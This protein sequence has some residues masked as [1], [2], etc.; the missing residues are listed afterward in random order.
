M[1]HRIHMCVYFCLPEVDFRGRSNWSQTLIFP[2]TLD[3][4]RIFLNLCTNFIIKCNCVLANETICILWQALP[5]TPQ[6]GD[7]YT[8]GQP[9]LTDIVAIKWLYACDT[10]FV[11]GIIF[12]LKNTLTHAI[13][14]GGLHPPDLLLQRSTTGINSKSQNQ[15]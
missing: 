7:L 9:H 2:P 5:T 8:I 11:V 12:A 10:N 15:P 1:V 3:N 14:S 4:V 6:P 13:A